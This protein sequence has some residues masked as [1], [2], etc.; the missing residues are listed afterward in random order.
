M[1]EVQRPLCATVDECAHAGLKRM[2]KVD[3]RARRHG[4]LRG[5][6]PGHLWKTAVVLQDEIFSLRT[7]VPRPKL[8]TVFAPPALRM[9][10]PIMGHRNMKKV[11]RYAAVV[12]FQLH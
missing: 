9:M 10:T 3:H 5:R 11:T 8:P 2:Q 7:S 12:L 6:V 1:Q 4:G